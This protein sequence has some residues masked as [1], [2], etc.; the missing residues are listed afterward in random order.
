M[1][2]DKQNSE[3]TSQKTTLSSDSQM[4]ETF[5][6]KSQ[7]SFFR[8]FFCG[9]VA[10]GGFLKTV[11]LRVKSIFQRRP[12][13][14]HPLDGL[15]AIAIIWVLLMH[16]SMFIIGDENLNCLEDY[17]FYARAAKNGHMGVD[18]FFT[19]SGFLI[20]FILLKEL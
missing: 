20:G 5:V 19:I 11:T 13:S 15:R 16:S 2:E 14:L 4:L 6:P 10:N 3:E 17:S 7:E 18:I 8:V 12:S 9:K 1:S